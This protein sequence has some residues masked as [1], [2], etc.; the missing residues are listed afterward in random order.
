MAKTKKEDDEKEKPVFSKE[1]LL[2][3]KKYMF[4][5]DLLNILLKDT[6]EYTLEEVDKKINEFKIGIVKE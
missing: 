6:K 1:S 3:S 4:Q 5:K 2:N